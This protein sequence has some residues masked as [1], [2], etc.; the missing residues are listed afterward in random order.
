MRTTSI[1][2]ISK[3]FY[4]WGEGGHKVGR[5]EGNIIFFDFRQMAKFRSNLG[6]FWPKRA[7]FEI[8]PKKV[9]KFF[10]TPKTMIRAKN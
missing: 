9:K 3:F 7:I 8:T 6:Q 1:L 10:A 2:V 4:V 5:K